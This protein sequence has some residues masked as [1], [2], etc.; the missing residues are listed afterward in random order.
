[1]SEKALLT[2]AGTDPSGGAGIQVDLQV[3][4]DWGYHGV[5]AITAVVSQNT[6]GVTSFDPCRKGLLRS[7]LEV[8]AA[9]VPIAGVKIGM[10]PT[11]ESVEAVDAFLE[12]HRDKLDGPIV[13]DPVLASGEGGTVLSR[14]GAAEAM[15]D[16]LMGKADILTPNLPELETLIGY[17][18]T[19][20]ADARDAAEELLECG[21]GAVLFKSGHMEI[22]AEMV[23]D[24]LVTAD[25]ESTWLEPLERIPMD[26]HGTGCQ[27]SSAI[28]AALADGMSA[29][30]AVEKSRVYL[31]DLLHT[32]IRP[33]GQGRRIIVRAEAKSSR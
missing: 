11:L 6:V 13:L 17:S 30:E 16:T 8:L 32:Q 28:C 1:M 9:D 26:V 15:L 2:I 19:D 18:I 4:R 3:F 21:C 23:S 7:Q 24:M 20:R 31:N 27:L 25:G 14:L 22:E 33:I 12:G 5:S 10:L 29:L